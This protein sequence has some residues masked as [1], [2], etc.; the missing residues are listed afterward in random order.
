MRQITREQKSGPKA[1][2]PLDPE[3]IPT[4]CR[5]KILVKM[6]INEKNRTTNV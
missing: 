4:G 1:L 3:K 6:V 5:T 2:S